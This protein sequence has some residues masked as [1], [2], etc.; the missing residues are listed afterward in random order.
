MT[1]NKKR[2]NVYIPMETYVKVTQS[3]E[4][5]TEA[6]INS[7]DLYLSE[8]KPDN[9]TKVSQDLNLEVLNLQEARIKELQQLIKDNDGNLQARIEDLKTQLQAVYGQLSIKDDQIK[10][11]NENM[12][13]Q[14]FH[15]QSLIQENSRLN[16]KLLPEN[17]EA[18]KPWYKFW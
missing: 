4:S 11:Q 15:I 16:V 6:I 8:N 10:D 9:D 5:L 13:K 1:E 7:L 2:I 14:A 17:K 18:K 12:T 3:G